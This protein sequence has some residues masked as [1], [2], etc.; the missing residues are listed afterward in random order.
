MSP[1]QLRS[2]CTPN[3]LAAS[4]LGSQFRVRGEGVALTLFR[5]DS[6]IDH[7]GGWAKENCFHH[8][9]VPLVSWDTIPTNGY[10]TTHPMVHACYS[11]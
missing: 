10:S 4:F 2:W 8:C 5:V 1:W 9:C 6:R 7:E 3:S 11:I